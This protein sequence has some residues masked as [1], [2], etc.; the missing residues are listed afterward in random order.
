MPSTAPP[1]AIVIFGA[2]GDLAQRKLIPAI[3]EM[4]R[5]N[6]LNE[7][8]YVV[9]FAR[10][11]MTDEQYRKESE[12]AVNKFARTKPV[13]AAILRK[14]IERLHYFQG[15][16]YGSADAHQKL[17]ET[18]TALDTKYGN[19]EKNR[20]FYLSTPPNTFEP[21]ITRL[22]ER[23]VNPQYN[24]EAR[25]KRLIIEKPFG[26]D[27]PSAKA[28]NKLIHTYFDESQVFRIDHYLGKETVQNLMVMRFANSIFEPIWNYKYIDHVQITVSESLGVG[29][30]GGYYDRSGALRDMVQN[31]IFQLMAL[32]A[33]EPPAALD[34]VSIRDE[35]TKVYKSIRPIRPDQVDHYTVRGQYSA[36]SHANQT[37]EGYLKEKGVP[38]DSRTE[39]FAA[40]KLYIDNWRWSGMPFYIRTGKFLETKLSEVVVRFRSPPLTLFQKQTDSPVYPN[41]LVIKIAPEEGISW[42]LNA[43]VPGGAVNIKP[44]ALDF[45]YKSAFN[46]EAPE[47]YERL[48][49]DSMTGDQTL[50][51]R[52]DEAEAAWAVID[53]IEQGWKESKRAPDPYTP[54]SWGPKR[55]IDLIEHDGRRWM[56]CADG[57]P[58]PIVACSL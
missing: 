6:L 5:E 2:S 37:S 3:Y 33:M 25:F 14:V 20:L 7:N 29:S 41:D 32:V 58:E 56:H 9:G 10:S 31:H 38:A 44:V 26:Y 49:Y 39:T 52:G 24:P 19:N 27:L 4:A 48:I 50:F 36:G 1:C 23:A 13:D 28:L 30:R 57:Q 46:V 16:D 12:D 47:A 21:I 54:G 22:G 15:D 45:L 42:R 51:I 34:A 11:P 8:S 55:S 17:A 53:P 43:K 40:L 18:L 35:K